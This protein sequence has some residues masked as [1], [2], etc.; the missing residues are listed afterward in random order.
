M[1]INI[2]QLDN[3]NYL[4]NQK[5]VFKE[6]KKWIFSLLINEEEVKQFFTHLK[7]IKTNK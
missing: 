3:K 4:V 7:T 2:K 1:S 5:P 6:K